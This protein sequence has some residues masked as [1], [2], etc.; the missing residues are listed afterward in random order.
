MECSQAE[1]PHK[2]YG[3]TVYYVTWVNRRTLGRQW[4]Y[5]YARK[6]VAIGMG[7]KDRVGNDG[8]GG[9]WSYWG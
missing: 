7:K 4:R 9:W 6:A 2:I 8:D 5:M 1:R 3:R